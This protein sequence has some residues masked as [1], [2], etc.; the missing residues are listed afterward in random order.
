MHDGRLFIDSSTERS[1]IRA[2]IGRTD[3]V[4]FRPVYKAQ[5]D[6]NRH[7]MNILR[8]KFHDLTFGLPLQRGI[9]NF[10]K[11]SE[12]PAFCR[13][14]R[15]RAK[16]SL[17]E[18]GSSKV[19][20]ATSDKPLMFSIS[21][22]T[23]RIAA[24]ASRRHPASTMRIMPCNPF[25][26]SCNRSHRHVNNVNVDVNSN[27]LSERISDAATAFVISLSPFA[28]AQRRPR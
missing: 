17:H 12:S 16:P 7:L 20:Q 13:H 24:D 9:R 26:V 11:I 23:E 8:M 10:R 3:R 27:L 1:K 19:R 2:S 5:I 28:T 15:L 6:F 21:S 14:L 25:A 22:A 18:V 4:R